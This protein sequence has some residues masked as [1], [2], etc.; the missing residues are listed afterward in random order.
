MCGWKLKEHGINMRGDPR[1][2]GWRWSD[3]WIQMWCV[4]GIDL[5]DGY[6]IVNMTLMFSY[7]CF[8]NVCSCQR[9]I[10]WGL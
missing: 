9:V 6:G 4:R 10:P 1:L 5:M 8:M 2:M 7:C 3:V